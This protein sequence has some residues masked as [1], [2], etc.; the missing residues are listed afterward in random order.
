[1]SDALSFD[2]MT[3]TN[4][5]CPISMRTAY[6]GA[7]RIAPV[8][9]TTRFEARGARPAV[10]ALRPAR[11]RNRLAEPSAR[12]DRTMPAGT[13]VAQVIAQFD[14]GQTNNAR[15]VARLYDAADALGG[16]NPCLAVASL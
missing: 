16:E 11:R 13:Y 15:A 7:R 9:A 5:I 4:Q 8:A 3:S 12:L 14:A 2:E 10:D 1:M 6:F